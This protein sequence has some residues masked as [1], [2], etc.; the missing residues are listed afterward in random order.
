VI[1]NDVEDH[2]HVMLMGALH[3]EVLIG[4]LYFRKRC[5]TLAAI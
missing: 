5:R 1:V 4:K 2:R 3:F